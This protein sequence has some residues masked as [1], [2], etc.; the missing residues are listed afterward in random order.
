MIRHLVRKRRRHIVID[1]DTQRDFL[2]ANGAACIRNHRRILGRIRRV[3]AWARSNHIAVISTC[4]VHPSNGNGNGNAYCIDG[5]DG[6]KKVRYTLLNNRVKYAADGNTDLPTDLLQRYSQIVLHKRCVDPFDEPR[7][8]RL[9]SDIRADEFI[10]I[11]ASAEGAVKA[12][13][14]GLLQRGKRVTIVVDAV[15]LH[16]KK[17]AK[18]A[19][20]KMEAKGARLIETKKLAG[21]SHLRRVGICDCASCRGKARKAGEEIEL[22]VDIHVPSGVRGAAEAG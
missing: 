13:A 9:L 15:G 4:E 5:T 14:L 3:M 6:Q 2:V 10:L 21:V 8:D 17:E 20:R 1:C 11:G 18:M 7:I 16:D 22:D 19:L 12:T